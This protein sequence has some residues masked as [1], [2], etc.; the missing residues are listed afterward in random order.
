MPTFIDLFCG[1]GGFRLGLEACGLKCVFSSEI[2]KFSRQ[3]YLANFGEEPHGDITKID[4]KDIPP[5]DVLC[6]GFPCQSFSI[7][8]KQLGFDE[9]RGQLFYEIIRIAKHHQPRFL[10]LENVPN[11][12]THDK[13][14]TLKTIGRLLGEAG[15]QVN[16]SV[17]NSLHFGIPQARGRVYFVCI[18]KDLDI[19]YI[20]PEPTFKK[21]S[22]KDIVDIDNTDK[23]LKLSEFEIERIDYH[24][25]RVTIETPRVRHDNSKYNPSTKKGKHGVFSFQKPDGSLRFHVGDVAKT[26]IQEA[27]YCCLNTY[28]P[29]IIANRTPKLWDIKRKLSVDEA[30]RLQGFPDRFRFPVSDGQAYKQFGNAVI[31][32]MIRLLYEALAQE[33]TF[34]SLR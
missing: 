8:G 3:T 16:L 24:F 19:K 18:R 25:T 13:G 14:R 9:D 21:C 23:S 27:F 31:P 30:R 29:T 5:H 32:K 6:A 33:L 7:A 12:L 26:Q 20:Q 2:D 28:A 15:Y 4:A 10:L 11:I 1:I 22:L 17:L 34:N